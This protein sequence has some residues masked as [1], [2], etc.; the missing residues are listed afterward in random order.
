MKIKPLTR[1]YVLPVMLLEVNDTFEMSGVIYKVCKIT[2][3]DI[4]YGTKQS[5]SHNKKTLS[6]NSKQ[7]V[8]LINTNPSIY[9]IS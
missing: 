4:Y 6:R 8:L 9:F 7:K 3:D 2:R 5:S 1:P